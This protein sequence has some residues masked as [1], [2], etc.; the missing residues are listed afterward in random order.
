[1]RFASPGEPLC[2]TVVGILM[3]GKDPIQFLPGAYIQFVRFDGAEVTDPI[4]DQREIGGPLPELLR[5]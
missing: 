3:I 5:T 2:P 4:Q 1:M